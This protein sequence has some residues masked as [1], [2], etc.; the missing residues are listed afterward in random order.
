MAHQVSRNFQSLAV[1]TPFFGTV[2]AVTHPHYSLIPTDQLF[3]VNATYWQNS[4]CTAPDP[5]QPELHCQVA[6]L[7][8]NGSPGRACITT[9]LP[10]Y[11]SLEVY[12]IR[13]VLADTYDLLAVGSC[14]TSVDTT[15]ACGSVKISNVEFE[16]S[17]V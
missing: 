7:R 16:S 17:M 11:H 14:E 8:D 4:R 9:Y 3:Q 6:S 12:F 15:L 2:T 13:M 1:P 5:E 10:T